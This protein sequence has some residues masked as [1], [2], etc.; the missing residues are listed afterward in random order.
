MASDDPGLDEALF[1][2]T[3]GEVEKGW[4]RGPPSADELAGLGPF[5]PSRRFGIVQGGKL[6]PIDDYSISRVNDTLAAS[7]SIDTS[8]VDHIAA[9]CRL[10]GDTVTKMHSP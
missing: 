10:L 3:L 9:N 7:E 4:L 5:V 1:A 2:H 6:R 8:D